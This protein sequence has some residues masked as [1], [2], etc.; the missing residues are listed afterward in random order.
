M[1]RGGFG[2]RLAGRSGEGTDAGGRWDPG[3][4]GAVVGRWMCLFT[5]QAM[6]GLG[7][8]GDSEAVPATRA[9]GTLGQ[10]QDAHFHPEA[11]S[12]GS[13]QRPWACPP[14]L[15][16]ANSLFSVC[17]RFAFGVSSEP[18]Q[19]SLKGMDGVWSPRWGRRPMASG[20]ELGMESWRARTLLL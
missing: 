14:C 4:G 3:K 19:V 1:V 7:P 9:R 15:P 16:R 12:C 20:R 18:Q 13:V 6:V 10:G 17:L 8:R 5:E 2:G 11:P